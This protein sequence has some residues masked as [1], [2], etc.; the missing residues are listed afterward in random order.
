MNITTIQTSRAK[1]K[2]QQNIL[3]R[4]CTQN[5]HLE[6]SSEVIQQ[7]TKKEVTLFASILCMCP[8]RGFWTMLR[9]R[10]NYFP[11]TLPRNESVIELVVEHPLISRDIKEEIY[12]GKHDSCLLNLFM[13]LKISKLFR[14]SYYI[15]IKAF[16]NPSTHSAWFSKKFLVGVNVCTSE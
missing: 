9:Y 1:H 15:L 8:V 13:S 6:Q 11:L 5:Y 16:L 3:H 14:S 4:K 12:F 7:M 2:S 10:H